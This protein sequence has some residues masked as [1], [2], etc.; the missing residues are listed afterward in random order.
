MACVYPERKPGKRVAWRADSV[1]CVAVPLIYTTMSV[2]PPPYSPPKGEQAIRDYGVEGEDHE[3]AGLLSGVDTTNDE[4]TK[5]VSTRKPF[6]WLD[7]KSSKKRK[8]LYIL[9]IV[10]IGLLLGAALAPRYLSGCRG[11]SAA[12]VHPNSKFVGSELRSN[13]THD[14]KRTVLIVSI[15]GLRCA[16]DALSQG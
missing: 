16:S 5:P 10:F 13:G 8:H 6:R 1:T 3:L 9:A 15:D 7:D 12:G 4:S 11:T 14:F 2:P